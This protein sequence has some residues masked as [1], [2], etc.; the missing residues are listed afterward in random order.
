MLQNRIQIA[1][2]KIISGGQTGV[3]RGA[4]DACIY[5]RFKHS[6]WCPKGRLAE[7][8]KI[9][10]KYNL[11]ETAKSDYET[12][13]YKNVA[14]SDATIIISNAKL[15]GGTLL[16]KQFA[17]NLDKPVLVIYPEDSAAENLIIKMITFIQNNNVFILNVA[18]PRKSEWNVGYEFAFKLISGLIKEIQK[19]GLNTAG[20]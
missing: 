14:D 12:R 6:G 4:L 8:G 19:T 16:T 15:K 2:Q 20:L 5:K 7:D 18:G 11:K 17:E 9:D 10:T 3:D 1:C 13:T